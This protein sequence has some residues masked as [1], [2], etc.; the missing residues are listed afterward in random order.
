M[1]EAS[2]P[3]TADDRDYDDRDNTDDAK[4]TSGA[5]ASV[6]PRLRGVVQ[7]SHPQRTRNTSDRPDP[8]PNSSSSSRHVE[9]AE[10]GGM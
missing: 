6:A 10:T 5:P 8:I 7:S 2:S 3:L 4:R 9:L 1:A